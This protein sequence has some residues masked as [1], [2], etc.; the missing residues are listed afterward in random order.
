MYIIA[1][2]KIPCKIRSELVHSFAPVYELLFSS[3]KI[4][5][6]SFVSNN[7]LGSSL[8]LFSDF[9]PNVALDLP[10]QRLKSY[11]GQQSS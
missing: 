3:L 1:N 9:L 4:L 11:V 6:V 7:F 8:S 2:F 5:T 10:H